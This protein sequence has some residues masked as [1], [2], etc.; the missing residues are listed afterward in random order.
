M[1][2]FG[3]LFIVFALVFSLFAVSG[4][5]AVYAQGFGVSW[6]SSFQVLNLS[7]TDNANIQ[8]YYYKQDG[9]L[10]A[11]E[12]GYLNPDSDTVTKGQSNTYYPIHAAAGFNGSVVVSSDQPIA[13]I[14]NLVVNTTAKALGSYVAFESGANTI[15]FPLL[16]KGNASQTSTFNVQ[17]TGSDSVDITIKFTPE[18]GSSYPTISNVTD[19]I[20]MGAAHTYD[21]GV[22]SGFSGVSKWVGSATVEV[23][24]TADSIA[25]VAST[26]NQKYGDAY[27][28]ATYNAFNS[29]SK[30][31][32][33]PLIQEN[34]S[35]NRTSI[36][37]QNIDPS[38]TTTISVAYTPEAGSVAKASENKSGITPNGIAVFLQDYQG[39]AKFVGSATVT[40]SPAVPLVCVVN[41]Q[42][43][44]VG[45]YSAYE[46]FDPESASGTVVLPLIQSRNGNATNGWVYSSIN[47]A[48][49]DGASHSITCDFKPAPGFTD[50]ANAT[51]SGASVVFVQSDLYGDGSKY[52]G[53][54]I[55]K[56]GDSAGLFAIVNQT[57]QSSP[58]TPRDVL[59]SY[60]GFN[61]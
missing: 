8:M 2:K 1:K 18:V 59:S 46:G 24:D 12:A 21:L 23:Q 4:P 48:T 55:C 15:Y 32:L 14:S 27:Q 25:G 6:D 31:V 9:T 16:M 45:R 29:G 28:L 50:P 33:L 60:D 36:N 61:Q 3:V 5:R 54:A 37:C 51:G 41:Q 13:V 35:G 42:K 26:V 22:L 43:P 39:S 56:T 38:T 20:P 11:M 49:A 10:A 7:D 58:Q 30:T 57:R 40:S 53:G 19:T 34:N 17:N 47:L 44:S 52:I